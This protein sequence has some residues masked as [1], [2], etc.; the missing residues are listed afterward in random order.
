MRK[1]GREQSS[2]FSIDISKNI[3][4]TFVPKIDLENLER[5][6]FG[7][8]IVEKINFATCNAC[9]PMFQDHFGGIAQIRDTLAVGGKFFSKLYPIMTNVIP[10]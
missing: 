7:K 8:S 10:I 2:S 9:L 6:A 1:R 5:S 3:S 4:I